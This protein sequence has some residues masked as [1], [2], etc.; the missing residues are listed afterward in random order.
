[1]LLVFSVI[2]IVF[3][4]SCQIP[5][6]LLF[7]QVGSFLRWIHE[8]SS[9]LK[10]R[11]F[12]QSSKVWSG[13]EIVAVMEKQGITPATFKIYCV[14]GSS[15][16]FCFLSSCFLKGCTAGHIFMTRL[17]TFYSSTLKLV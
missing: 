17:M 11:S 16:P 13:R 9:Q 3:T 14:S 12:E 15:S 2:I 5:Y 8:S 7:P 4:L 1:M 10:E 6:N